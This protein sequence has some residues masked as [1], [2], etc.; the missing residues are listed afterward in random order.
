M[1]QFLEHFGMFHAAWKPIPARIPRHL[2]PRRARALL[3]IGKR[4]LRKQRL[5][6]R[7]ICLDEPPAGVRFV[8]IVRSRP[9]GDVQSETNPVLVRRRTFPRLPAQAILLEG[10]LLEPFRVAEELRK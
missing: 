9:G 2:V 7:S 3:L 1:V 5:V 6:R 4:S 10:D 8:V